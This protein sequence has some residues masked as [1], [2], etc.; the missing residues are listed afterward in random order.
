VG[1]A[2]LWTLATGLGDAFTPEV[3]QAWTAAYRTLADAM[4]EAAYE[5]A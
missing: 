4:K 5:T 1:A 3:K 2:L